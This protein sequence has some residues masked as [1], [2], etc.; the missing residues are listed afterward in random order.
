MSNTIAASTTGSPGILDHN[1]FGL[2]YF[3]LILTSKL[4]D[5]TIEAMKDFLREKRKG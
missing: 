1:Q 5:T 2:R 4:E 3:Q